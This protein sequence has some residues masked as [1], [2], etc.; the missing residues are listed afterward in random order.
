MPE[1]FS[2]RSGED[3]LSDY[4]F[5]RGIIHHLFC[6]NC[7]V[8][9]FAHGRAPDGAATVAINARC[10]DGVDMLSLSRIPFDGRSR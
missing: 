3:K 4:Q 8:E 5:N 2:L 6:S 7:G 1:Q 10:L 9:S